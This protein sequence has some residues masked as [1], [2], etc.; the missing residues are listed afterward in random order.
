[1]N[2]ASG[3]FRDPSGKVSVRDGTIFRAVFER[4]K[5]QYDYLM[6]SG[7]NKD[8][9]DCSLLVRHEQTDVP[10]PGAYKVLKPQQLPFIPYA[11]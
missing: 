9:V 4:Y 11:Y 5:R 8:L 3:S 1:M 7:L 6:S 2:A 10:Y